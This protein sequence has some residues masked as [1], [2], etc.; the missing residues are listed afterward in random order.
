MNIRTSLRALED[1]TQ[2]W[3]Q[4][5]ADGPFAQVW[6]ALI[7]FLES[8]ILP[9]PPSAFMLA[10]IALGKRHKW[11]YL[12]TLTTITSVLGGL[13]GYFIGFTLYDTL[14]RWVITQYHLADDIARVA[15]LFEQHAFLANFVGAFTPIPYKAFTLASGFFSINIFAF[16]FASLA[17]RGLRFFVI[18]YLA[19]V[20]GE[21]V[22]HRVFRYV[23]F[24]VLFAVAIMIIVA[25]IGSL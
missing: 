15:L 24:L 16:T 6:L 9:L 2:A 20:F 12:A 19:K 1:R 5:H 7:A 18:G 23:V 11:L 13:F 3:M 14:G 22:T 21:K 10:M 4:Y 17:G 25:I 8:S